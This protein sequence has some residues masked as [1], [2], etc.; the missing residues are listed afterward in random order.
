MNRLLSRSANRSNASLSLSLWFVARD[1]DRDRDQYQTTAS[2]L[3]HSSFQCP[4]T[5]LNLSLRNARA[6]EKR[7]YKWRAMPD[8]GPTAAGDH[9]NQ[10]DA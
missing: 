2:A 5:A 1:R 6:R 10:E 7:I 4:S 3:S 9:D 8:T